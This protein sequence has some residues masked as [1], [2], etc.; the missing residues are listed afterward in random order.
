[1]C[2]KINKSPKK[3]FMR[4]PHTPKCLGAVVLAHPD[5]VLSP[6]S[7]DL[8]LSLYRSPSLSR[9]LALRVS[10]SRSRSLSLALSPGLSTSPSLSRVCIRVYVV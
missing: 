8:S 9:F 4:A 7:L 2:T 3:K 10:I 1:M 6:L 5:R